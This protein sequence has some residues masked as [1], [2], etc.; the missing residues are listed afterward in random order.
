MGEITE[1][2]LFDKRLDSLSEISHLLDNP[3][4]F[5]HAGFY[6]SNGDIL[7][8]SCNFMFKNIFDVIEPNFEHVYNTVN[9]K[10]Y[11]Y[12]LRETM[13]IDLHHTSHMHDFI[14]GPCDLNEYG[15]NKYGKVA[16]FSNPPSY[17][18]H[19]FINR[20][21]SF[22]NVSDLNFS[23]LI[24]AHLGF[25]FDERERKLHCFDCNY[26]LSNYIPLKNQLAQH[27]LQPCDYIKRVFG[28]NSAFLPFLKCIN[29][30]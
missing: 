11:C 14:S 20:F 22:S 4:S 21:T 5:A 9:S 6:Y 23:P 10:D 28:S 15:P 12:Y 13:G 1:W 8:H 30:D 26:P 27:M 29:K 18:Y 16:Y 25:C 2:K 7:C 3:T 19:L 17:G 24:L